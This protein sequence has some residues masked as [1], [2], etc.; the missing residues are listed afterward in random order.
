M[1]F[2]IETVLVPIDASAEARTAAA[3]ALG[4]AERYGASVHALYVVDESSARALQ[5]GEL[6][7]SA[8]AN[9]HA[10]IVDDIEARAGNVPVTHSTAIGFSPSRLRQHPGSVILDVA[11]ELAVD[12]IVIPREPAGNPEDAIG[13]SAQYVLE[14]ASQPVLSV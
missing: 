2:D 9:E 3:Y 5:T 4:V 10:D 1:A 11:E 6:D 12:F 7:N 8:I 14:Y 13:K